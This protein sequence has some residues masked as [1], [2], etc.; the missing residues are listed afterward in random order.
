[1]RQPMGEVVEI[2]AADG[3]VLSAY[4]AGPI[5][6]AAA[7]VIVQEVFGVNAHLRFG[8]RCLR[9]HGIPRHR[10]G[11]V[12]QGRTRGRPRLHARR[13]ASRTGGPRPSGTGPQR[14]STSPRR[15]VASAGRAQ[16]RW[17]GI[18]SAEASHGWPPT[19]SPSMPPSA[20]TGARSTISLM[21]AAAMP[22]HAAFRRA[23]HHDPARPYCGHQRRPSGRRGARLRRRRPRIQLR[24]PR[25]VS[26]I[27]RSAGP[28]ANQRVSF[29]RTS[30]GSYRAKD[31]TRK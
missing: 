20:T 21:S 8:R 27:G 10:A 30:G 1:M 16:L 4:T 6:A 9:G 19:R 18:A 24:H 17:W 29:A 14:R 23:R 15:S 11:H 12:R 22:D 25:L 3:H 28:A 26:P 2:E 7:V 31:E 5:D 13:P